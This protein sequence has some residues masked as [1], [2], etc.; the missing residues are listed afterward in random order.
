MYAQGKRK[1]YKVGD[2]PMSV[3]GCVIMTG[4]GRGLYALKF[5]AQRIQVISKKSH[6]EIF[7]CATSV[8]VFRLAFISSISSIVLSISMCVYLISLM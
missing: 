5:H 4:G 7:Y 8:R 2:V 3:S 1:Y 6:M